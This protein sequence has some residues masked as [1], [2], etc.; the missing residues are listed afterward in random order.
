MN[1]FKLQMDVCEVTPTEA[2]WN[3]GSVNGDTTGIILT[4]LKM[5]KMW[6]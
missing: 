5:L 3:K 4:H 1:N 6:L 2:H